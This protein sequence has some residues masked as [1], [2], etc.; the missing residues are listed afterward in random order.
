MRC[1]THDERNAVEAASNGRALN[2]HWTADAKL[3]Y[4]A[5]V[6]LMSTDESACSP[7]QVGKC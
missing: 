2:P 4:D 7:G 1:F 3:L 5:I 6:R